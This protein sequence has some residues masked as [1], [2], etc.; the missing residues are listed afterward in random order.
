MV[1]AGDAFCCRTLT[2]LPVL[3]RLPR[4]WS[5]RWPCCSPTS[6]QMFGEGELWLNDGVPIVRRRGGRACGLD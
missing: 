5:T 1:A 4:T 3:N 2:V 6:D